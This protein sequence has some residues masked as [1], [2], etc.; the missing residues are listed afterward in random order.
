[1]KNLFINKSI[2]EY[3]HDIFIR[4]RYETAKLKEYSKTMILIEEN[5]IGKGLQIFFA[6]LTPII[7]SYYQRNILV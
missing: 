7:L 4:I 3:I 5:I 1:M 2:L 6:A